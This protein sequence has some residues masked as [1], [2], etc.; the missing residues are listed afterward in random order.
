MSLRDQILA[1]LGEHPDGLTSKELAPLCPS[2]E[3]D[4]SMIGR[5]IAGLRAANEIRAGSELRD[6]GA[7][8][9]KGGE[10][11][12]AIESKLSLPYRPDLKPPPL[13]EAARAIAAMRNKEPT[14]RASARP[15]SRP[16]PALPPVPHQKPEEEP[17]AMSTVREKIE[18]ALRAHGPM[19]SRD[20][21]KHVSAKGLGQH[22][23]ELAT[24]GVLKKFKGDGPR[25]GIYALPD[26]KKGEVEASPPTEPKAPKTPKTPKKKAVKAKKP[27]KTSTPRAERRDPPPAPTNGDARFAIDEAGKLGIE[28]EGG[29]LALEPEEF[30]RLRDFIE[31]TKPVWDVA[32]A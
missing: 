22:C 10:E 28:K 32:G 24:R 15:V 23:F 6:G 25:S 16:V 31:R 19:T 29:K 27:S 18:A 3:D 21:A 2:C 20:L 12:E 17:A 14:E 8:W 30:E 9:I 5:V 1:A 7:I 26:Q 11:R 13:S 4:L